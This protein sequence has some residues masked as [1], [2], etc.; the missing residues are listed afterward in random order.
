MDERELRARSL[1]KLLKEKIR[2]ESRL[3]DE[4]YQ[5]RVSAFKFVVDF[6]E[7]D[8]AANRKKR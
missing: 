4:Y 5:G 6:M 8:A 1:K 7:D 3:N 2:D